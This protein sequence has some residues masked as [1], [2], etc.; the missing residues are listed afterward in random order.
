[1]TYTK[2]YWIL[3][4]IIIPPERPKNQGFKSGYNFI[5]VQKTLLL[6]LNI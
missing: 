5:S 1:M 3:A 2:K 4:L 6:Y